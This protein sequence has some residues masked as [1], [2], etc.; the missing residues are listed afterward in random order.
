MEG[1]LRISEAASLAMH[2]MAY[3]ASKNGSGPVP[4]SE[5]SSS[6]SV[7]E[8]HMGKVLQRLVKHGFLTSRRG[9]RGGYAMVREARDARLLDVYEA[10]EGPLRQAGC[11]LGHRACRG[12]EC[13]LGDLVHVVNEQVRSH[14]SSTRVSDLRFKPRRST[15]GAAIGSRP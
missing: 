6:L 2:A 11:L 12:K 5:V 4:V 1:S 8:A 15:G 7:S 10:V 13:I 14:L 3:I 9:P